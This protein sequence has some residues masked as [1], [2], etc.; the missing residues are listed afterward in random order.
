MKYLGIKK[1][2][3]IYSKNDSQGLENLQNIVKGKGFELFETGI[4]IDGNY[5]TWMPEDDYTD[6]SWIQLQAEIESMFPEAELDYSEG[7]SEDEYRGDIINTETL[8]IEL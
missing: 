7:E 4:A 5:E 8:Q 3:T 6:F 1:S 2:I